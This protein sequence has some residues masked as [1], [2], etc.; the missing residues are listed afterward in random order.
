MH[1]ILKPSKYYFFLWNYHSIHFTELYCKQEHD[2]I[3][4]TM[5]YHLFKISESVTKQLLKVSSWTG[6]EPENE[7]RGMNLTSIF[8]SSNS[9]LLKCFPSSPY[10]IY[11]P[12]SRDA[13][14]SCIQSVLLLNQN[15]AK[16]SLILSSPQWT[17]TK[18]LAGPSLLQCS[19]AINNVEQQ[20]GK[21]ETT[22]QVCKGNALPNY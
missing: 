2:L 16:G 19:S 17:A 4:H 1:F 14:L 6:T 12:F 9:L 10:Q 13:A 22:A 11:L 8:N 7:R 21:W 3:W 18:G 20:T 15:G 5:Y